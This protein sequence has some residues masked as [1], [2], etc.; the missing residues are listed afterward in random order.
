MTLDWPIVLQTLV[1]LGVGGVLTKIV[2]YLLNGIKGRTSELEQT[3]K[4]AREWQLWGYRVA[5][6]ALKKGIEVPPSPDERD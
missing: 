5:S 1:A 2:E 4:E 6:E 3:K